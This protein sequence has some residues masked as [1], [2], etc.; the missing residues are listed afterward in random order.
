METKVTITENYLYIG[1]DLVSA[2]AYLKYYLN[3][4]NILVAEGTKVHKPYEG[5][6]L[7]FLLFQTLIMLAEQKQAKIMTYCSYVAHQLSKSEFKKYRA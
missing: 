4:N 5:Q 7:G 1:S 2:K 6:G 3:R